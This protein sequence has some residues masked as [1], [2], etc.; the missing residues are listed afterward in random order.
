MWKTAKTL[1]DD[2][3]DD[4]RDT[5]VNTSSSID[6]SSGSETTTDPTFFGIYVPT[7]A[8]QARMADGTTIPTVQQRVFAFVVPMPALFRAGILASGVGYGL[9]AVLVSLRTVVVPSYVTGTVPVNIV[10]AALYTGCFMALVS[11]VRYQILQGLIEPILID[12][13]LF[14]TTTPFPEEDQHPRQQQHQQKQHNDANTNSNVDGKSNSTTTATCS[15]SRHRRPRI[16]MIFRPVLIFVIRWLNGLLGSV[17]A[18][19][20]MRLCGLQRMKG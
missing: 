3:L 8:F 4:G 2:H 15:G 7:N 13:W 12:R 5:S 10:A 19:N 20:G 9:A 16:P 11:N 17:L 6:I 1:D 14:P 18:I